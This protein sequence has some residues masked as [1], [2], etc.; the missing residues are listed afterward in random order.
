MWRANSRSLGRV[1]ER[2]GPSWSRPCGRP[3]D[4]LIRSRPAWAQ[5]KCQQQAQFG[6]SETNGSGM[7]LLFCLRDCRLLDIHLRG[8]P[9][10]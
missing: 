5:E 6:N 7:P 3:P 2:E 10:T 1:L 8:S 9:E 4:D